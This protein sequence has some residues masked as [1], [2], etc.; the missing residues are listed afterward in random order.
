MATQPL[1]ERQ[2]ILSS[3]VDE[4]RYER[5]DG[6]LV[7]RPVPGDI[8]SDFQEIFRRLL[9]EQAGNLGYKARSEWSVTRPDAAHR[10][11]PDYMTPDVLVAS[12]PYQRTGTGHLIPPGFL[13]VEI[14]SPGQDGL[15]R[16]AQIYAAWG[17]EHVWIVNPQTREAFEYHG[18]NQFTI[19]KDALSA[20]DITVRLADVF[21]NA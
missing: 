15:I 11:E 19:V 9:S 8:H 1:I 13:A 20:G 12:V 6:Q 3:Y 14:T 16:K 17:I 4:S 5:I 7:P 18:G 2:E 10:A 21:Q